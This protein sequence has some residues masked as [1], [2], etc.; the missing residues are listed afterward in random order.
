[1][2]LPVVP[3]IAAGAQL[4]SQGINALSQGN[5]NRKNRNFSR[6]MYGRQ[7]ADSLADWNMQNEYNSPRAMM[8]R[9]QEAGLNPHLIYGQSNEAG[10]VRGSSVPAGTGKAP[11]F[12]L[13][14][15]FMDAYDL[16]MRSAQMDNVALQGEVLRQEAILK[17]VQ[18][19][20]IAQATDVSRFDL[21]LKQD[22][23]DNTIASLEASLHNMLR[24]GHKIEADTK[25]TLDQNER[26]AAMQAY[27][28]QEAVVRI[29]SIRMSTIKSDEERA[30]IKQ[31]VEN[32]KKDGT[33]KDWDIKLREMGI[34]PGDP[35]WF[36]V[37]NK[38][39]DK[40]DTPPSVT[41][42][43]KQSAKEYMKSNHSVGSY[44]LPQW[45]RK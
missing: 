12:D 14:R 45:W 9:Y 30:V 28:I 37:L 11:Q 18:S 16:K 7:R 4:A 35:G 5:M 39:L 38:V 44:L 23:R 13:S 41:P 36:R 22:T 31:T 17:G 33:L 15:P 24:T 29:A 2:P 10:A 34:H 1:M 25:F 6:E 20:S 19:L 32:L 27:T 26:A 40:L 3:L 43:F 42:E 21:N 8:Q